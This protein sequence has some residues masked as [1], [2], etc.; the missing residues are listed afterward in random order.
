MVGWYA[1]LPG[2]LISTRTRRAM[3]VTRN[4]SSRLLSTR[5]TTSS[6]QH[7]SGGPTNSS[8]NWWGAEGSLLGAGGG[9]PLPASWARYF[10]DL[11]GQW[12]YVHAATQ[13]SSWLPPPEPPGS[14]DDDASASLNSKNSR[15]RSRKGARGEGRSGSRNGS[16]QERESGAYAL[17]FVTVRAPRTRLDKPPGHFR[18]R[19]GEMGWELNQETGESERKRLGS[20]R[21]R[22]K[23]MGAYRYQNLYL[24][25]RFRLRDILSSMRRRVIKGT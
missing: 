11:T 21:L 24:H 14:P 4:D 15:S 5:G 7:S 25:F 18:S 6:A 20:K 3:I 23:I 2:C 9:P 22:D 1:A 13:R 19:S 12:Y 10:D 16:P 17:P 8:E